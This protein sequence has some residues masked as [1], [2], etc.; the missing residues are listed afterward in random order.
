MKALYS[1]LPGRPVQSNRDLHG[2]HSATLQLIRKTIH[3]QKAITYRYPFIKLSELEQCRV[4]EVVQGSIDTAMQDWN[5]G[6]LSRE[7]VT[8]AT[9]S[10]RMS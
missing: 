10:Y 5:T 2:K 9:E 1:L 8:L 3:T 4:N 6:S 7:S